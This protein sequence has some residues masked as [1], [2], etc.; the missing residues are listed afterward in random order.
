[1]QK[2]ALM[3]KIEAELESEQQG[4]C[5]LKQCVEKLEAKLEYC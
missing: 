2:S 5:D 3:K 4:R 1:M